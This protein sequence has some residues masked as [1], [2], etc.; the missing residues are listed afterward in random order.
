MV[1]IKI[2]YVTQKR[3]KE[4]GR[5]F[6]QVI[7]EAFE[8]MDDPIKYTGI[9]YYNSDFHPNKVNNDYFDEFEAVEITKE[10]ITKIQRKVLL[11]MKIK[12]KRYQEYIK[13]YGQVEMIIAYTAPELIDYI[14][15]LLGD[16]NENL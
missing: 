5:K 16:E 1:K 2:Y 15:Y 8:F 9:R 3:K 14:D 10:N 13:Y 4:K 11:N 12:V 7:P 6:Y